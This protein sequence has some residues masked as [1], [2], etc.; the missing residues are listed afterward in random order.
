MGLQVTLDRIQQETE[1]KDINKTRLGQLGANISPD[2][3]SLT[4]HVFIGYFCL[5][6]LPV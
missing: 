4:Q 2:R 1:N 6:T 3:S 5:G